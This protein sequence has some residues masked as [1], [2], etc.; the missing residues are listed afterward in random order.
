MSSGQTN[1]IQESSILA[2]PL[3]KFGLDPSLLMPEVPDSSLQPLAPQSLGENLKPTADPIR[4][5]YDP[6]EFETLSTS[7][8]IRVTA[9]GP[10]WELTIDSASTPNEIIAVLRLNRLDTIAD[11]LKYLRQLVEDDPDEPPIAIESLRTLVN[12][13]LSER[14][15]P[16]PQIGVS[17]DGLAQ[18]EWRIPTNGILAM[19]FLPSGLIRFAAIS[20]T[21]QRSA[22][23]LRV[24]GTLPKKDALIAVR[25]FTSHMQL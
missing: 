7:V 10:A 21:A 17:P 24:N 3:A 8:E 13:L 16:N 5:T 23:R 18:V 15:L 6:V 14:Q 2:P 22:E 20:S 19:E 25:P 12:F 11:R 1:F 4:A 9:R